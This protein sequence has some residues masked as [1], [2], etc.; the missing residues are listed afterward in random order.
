MMTRTGTMGRMTSSSEDSVLDVAAAASQMMGLPVPLL[1]MATGRDGTMG[2]ALGAA[3]DVVVDAVRMLAL[4]LARLLRVLGLSLVDSC[5]WPSW[6]GGYVLP[7]RRVLWYRLQVVQMMPSGQSLAPW[8]ALKQ[9]KH[10][11]FCF[12]IST[13]SSGLVRAVSTLHSVAACC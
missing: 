12:R 4:V 9:W 5:G 10:R 11:C 6:R 7:W 3:F 2:C 13:L 1:L 8:S